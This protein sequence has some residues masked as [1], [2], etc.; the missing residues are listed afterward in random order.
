MPNAF[1]YLVLFLWPLVVIVLFRIWPRP[2]ALV[3]ALVAGY[4]IV[5]EMKIELSGL[6]AIDKTLVITVSAAFMCLFPMR[7]A[8]RPAPLGA[9]GTAAAPAGTG[10]L[11]AGARISGGGRAGM[12]PE[13]APGAQAGRRPRGL[14]AAMSAAD[15]VLAGTPGAGAAILAPPVPAAAG[16]AEVFVA[17]DRGRVLFTAL[18]V[19]LFITPA[20]TVWQNPEPVIVGPRFIPGL[21]IYDAVSI[22]FGIGISVLPFMLGRRYLAHPDAH[23]TLLKGFAVAALV[24][25]AFCLY[26][27]RMSPQLNRMLYGFF[28]HDFLQHIRA[29][30]FRPVVFLHHGL[31]LGIF[32]AMSVL[33]AATLYRQTLR[34]PRKAGEMTPALWMALAL[35]LF[36]VLYLAKALGAFALTLLLL[37]LLLILGVQGHLVIAMIVAGVTLFYPILRGAGWIP[38]EFAYETA[39]AFDAERGQSL[40]FRLDNEDALLERANEKPFAGW[41]SW[42]RPQLFDPWDGR[43][44]SVTDGSWI[45]LI[46]V[47]GWMGYIAHFGLL[48]APLLLLG[49]R[50]SRIG[51]G[52]ESS[53]LALVLA[54]NL[55]DLI[56]NATLT[57]L[58]FLVAGA[59]AGRYGLERR[60]RGAAA[61]PA[62]APLHPVASGPRRPRRGALPAGALLAAPVSGA[63]P[64]ELSPAADRGRQR[65]PRRRPE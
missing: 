35:W 61:E 8:V 50:R 30:G 26:E 28:P 16:T 31:W 24:Y 49:L 45:I 60:A 47:F 48:C 37:P 42:G 57:P 12:S 55:L 15:P 54:V 17:T 40:K 4:L 44:T 7:P 63:A 36:L 33:A 38:T 39:L 14:T 46:G 9:G 59:L 27:V 41:G 65:Q 62:A 22:L 25:S 13:T 56:P 51:V 10:A 64:A 58:T 23:R 19:L 32:L 18:L 11:A 1:A 43:Q 29:G 20:L 5:P 3:A 52:I 34:A 53:G 21:R 2:T 6:P